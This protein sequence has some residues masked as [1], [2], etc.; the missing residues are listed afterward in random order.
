MNNVAMHVRKYFFRGLIAIIPLG[1]TTAFIYFLYTAVDRRLVEW[2]DRLLGFRFP[3]LGL[4][5]LLTI[6]YLLGLLASNIVAR[7]L[8]GLMDK[9]TNRIP[10]IRTTYQIGK[11]IAGTLTLPEKRVFR[12]AVLVPYLKTGLWTVGFETG[13]IEQQGN[14]G[15]L[16]LKIFIPTP[17]NPTSGT[18]AIVPESEI[19]DPGWSIEEGFKMVISAGI[20]GPTTIPAEAARVE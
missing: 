15:E 10:L 18:L 11:Q 6:L 5:L 9:A 2:I 19:R 1:L 4:L 12:R 17:P 3:G 14:E 20:I 8:T 13:Y 16:M 7:Q